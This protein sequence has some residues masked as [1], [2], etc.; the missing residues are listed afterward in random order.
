MRNKHIITAALAALALLLPGSGLAQ[1]TIGSWQTSSSDGWIDWGNQLS[2]TDVSYTNKY[3]FAPGVVS[4]YA[5]SLQI[6][7][8]GYNQS[9]S[10][11][12]QNNGYVDD[13]T[14]NNRLT[15]TFSVPAWTN[16]GY[17]QLESFVVNAPGVGFT[18]QAFDGRWSSTGS[19][20]DND[21][22]KPR[23]FFYAGSPARSQTV[24]LDYSS[25]FTSL[26]PNPGYVE[27]IFTFNNGG[28]APAFWYM[29]NVV[30]SSA[31]T[32]NTNVVV[33]YP[34]NE[35]NSVPGEFYPWS[36]WFGDATDEPAAEWDPSDAGGDANSGSMKINAFFP[37]AGY[38]YGGG[39]QFVVHNDYNG[40]ELFFGTNG[41]P[42]W[43][44]TM[45]DYVVTNISFDL[46]FDPASA[47]VTNSG[48]WPG[49]EIGTRGNTN[50]FNQYT[51]GTATIPHSQTN[52][53]HFN[54]PIGA[55]ADWASSYSLFFKH[56]SADLNGPVNFYVDN[57]AVTRGVVPRPILALEKAQ[58]GLRVFAGSS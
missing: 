20:N 11:K 24:T 53:V 36:V 12:L 48:N 51:Y 31:T 27:L 25:L 54:I 56:Y 1:T 19:T 30:L 46:R 21:G 29:N 14:N 2:I 18:S 3:S 28:G 33:L 23:F 42:C 8:A 4:G 43:G 5:Q 39:P 52:W 55:N 10:I 15:F 13:F 47:Y 41:M 32:V 35:T 49:I 37:D 6:T 40:L 26:T 17:S 9:L 22:T 7:Q 58:P 38:G 57:I 44:N 45:T 50:S 16:G 34:F